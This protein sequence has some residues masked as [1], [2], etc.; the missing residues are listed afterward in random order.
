MSKPNYKHAGSD[1]LRMRMLTSKMVQERFSDMKGFSATDRTYIASLLDS[2][3]EL[4]EPT[5]KEL[6][7]QDKSLEDV[8]RNTRV[9]LGLKPD[10]SIE[11]LMNALQSLI[12]R[13]E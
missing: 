9:R 10:E 2:P 3:G 5:K 12:K 11:I 7:L 1:S 13:K 6:R 8:M 4:K